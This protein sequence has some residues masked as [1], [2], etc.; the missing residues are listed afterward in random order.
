MSQPN[1]PPN[2]AP[3]A[4]PPTPPPAAPPVA[5]ILEP[6]IPKPAAV[7]V[8]V[9]D[10]NTQRYKLVDRSSLDELPVFVVPNDD[11]GDFD[12]GDLGH[13]WRE[14]RGQYFEGKWFHESA[15]YHGRARSQGWQPVS[16]DDYRDPR[17]TVREIAGLGKCITH[18]DAVLFEMPK[19]QAAARLE[20]YE[21]R[22]R[23]EQVQRLYGLEQT[24]AGITDMSGG[25][26]QASVKQTQFA[27]STAQGQ[28]EAE[29]ESLARARRYQTNMKRDAQ[30][31]IPVVR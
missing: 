10:D 30:R 18:M 7:L 16:P 25:Y 8:A 15:K 13:K 22:Q 26:A 3:P 31:L 9:L 29:V 12:I 19:E 2:P 23:Y 17:Y 28:A 4:A 20:A 21:K 5:P 6:I 24:A 27:E 11:D 1:T 14:G